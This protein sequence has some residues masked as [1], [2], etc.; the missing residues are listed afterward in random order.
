VLRA[1][2][3]LQPVYQ[4]IQES[5]PNAEVITPDETGWRNGGR[6]VWLHA[7]VTDQ[8]TC[9]VIDPHRSADALE[10]VIGLDYSGTLIHDG[11]ST[12]DRFLDAQH[13]QCVA[14]ALRRAVFRKCIPIGRRKTSVDLFRFAPKTTS[15]GS[16]CLVPYKRLSQV[17]GRGLRRRVLT[18]RL[19]WQC[20]AGILD[21]VASPLAAI[22]ALILRY[23]GSV[24]FEETGPFS[25][26]CPPPLRGRGMAPLWLAL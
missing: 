20:P 5:L 4:E 8:A 2:D 3:K 6:L 12:Y 22:F 10:E 13:Q 25:V 7:W 9:Y 19:P 14:H 26:G 18:L 11:A 17:L 15:S 16:A 1:A 24:F 23:R 21:S